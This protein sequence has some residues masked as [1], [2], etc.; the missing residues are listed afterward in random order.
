M[1]PKYKQIKVLIEDFTNSVKCILNY[2]LNI[3]ELVVQGGEPQLEEKAL[4]ERLSDIN[5]QATSKRIYRY[6]AITKER[7]E[8]KHARTKYNYKA[9]AER[10]TGNECVL[11]LRSE[12]CL[13]TKT[14]QF[15][16]HSSHVQHQLCQ[17]F[18]NAMRIILQQLMT[19]SLLLAGAR[20]RKESR[21]PSQSRDFPCLRH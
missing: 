5:E 15:Y 21:L 8:L 1:L 9:K 7:K 12:A 19:R 6:K 14:Q 13:A 17:D 4:Q 2:P 11:I 3:K 20:R 10:K 18:R 16:L